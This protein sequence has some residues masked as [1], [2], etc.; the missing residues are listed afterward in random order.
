MEK[1]EGKLIL[2]L[3]Y[4]FSYI[5]LIV[6]KNRIKGMFL[7]KFKMYAKNNSIQFTTLKV[8]TIIWLY[9]I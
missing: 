4:N 8:E 7:H 5:F 3:V 2:S 6:I 1:N 9:K